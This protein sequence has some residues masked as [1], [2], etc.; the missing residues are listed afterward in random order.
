[1]EISLSHCGNPDSPGNRPI[2]KAFFSCRA[3]IEAIQ[4]KSSGG[5]YGAFEEQLGRNAQCLSL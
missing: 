1:M 4:E 3:G 5:N 2:Y